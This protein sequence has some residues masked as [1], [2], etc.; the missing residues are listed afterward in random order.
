MSDLNRTRKGR[1]CKNV[2]ALVSAVALAC[3]TTAVVVPSARAADVSMNWDAIDAPFEP[4]SHGLEFFP[5]LRGQI[6]RGR[7]K[8]RLIDAMIKL[9]QLLTE[10]F[11]I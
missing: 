5:P 8:P 3:G 1:V 10:P 11:T 2:A 6:C 7:P 4:I 9:D